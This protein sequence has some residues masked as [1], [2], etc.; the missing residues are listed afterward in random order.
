MEKRVSKAVFKA[1]ACELFRQ[2][3][4][5][6]ESVV[7]TDRGQPTIEI[8][9]YRNRRKNPLELLRASVVHFN[10]KDAPEVPAQPLENS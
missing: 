4:M 8:R 5:L 2:V 3:E 7:V 9:P 10:L 6:G 1:R